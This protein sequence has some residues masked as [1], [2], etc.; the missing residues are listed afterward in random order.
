MFLGIGF[1]Q[2]RENR[3]KNARRN[4][5]FTE[6]KYENKFNRILLFGEFCVIF[7]YQYKK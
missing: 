5:D 2:P 3:I 1:W 7:F 4:F 6:G